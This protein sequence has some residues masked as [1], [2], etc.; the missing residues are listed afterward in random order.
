MI[1]KEIEE[2]K[3]LV[4]GNPTDLSQYTCSLAATF[5]LN[6]AKLKAL[7][8]NLYTLWFNKKSM[9]IKELVPAEAMPAVYKEFKMNQ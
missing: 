1:I 3:V 5:G 8:G 9:V 6:Q 2:G 7:D 4:N